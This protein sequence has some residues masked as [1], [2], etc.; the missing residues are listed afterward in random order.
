MRILAMTGIAEIDMLVA[1]NR[2][3]SVRWLGLAR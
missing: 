2:A 3:N 1:M